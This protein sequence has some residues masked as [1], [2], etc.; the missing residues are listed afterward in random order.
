MKIYKDKLQPKGQSA[1][2]MLLGKKVHIFLKKSHL[3]F[4]WLKLLDF[5][6]IDYFS[7]LPLRDYSRND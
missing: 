6:L 1:S 4:R 2:Q 3:S 5:Y 7:I